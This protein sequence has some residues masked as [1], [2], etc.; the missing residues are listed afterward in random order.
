MFEVTFY[1]FKLMFCTLDVSFGEKFTGGADVL[2]G[3]TFE[4][5]GMLTTF[6]FILFHHRQVTGT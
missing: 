1:A 3:T 5:I 2:E 6:A 4:I